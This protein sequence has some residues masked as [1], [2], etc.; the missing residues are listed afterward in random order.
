M[1]KYIKVMTHP[2]KI[3]P[4]LLKF[5]NVLKESELSESCVIVYIVAKNSGL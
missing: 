5:A 2:L 1:L 4:L 3:M